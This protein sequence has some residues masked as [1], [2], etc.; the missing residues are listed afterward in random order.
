MDDRSGPRT[1]ECVEGQHHACRG[2]VWT[3]SN[4]YP[5]GCGCA[6][7]DKETP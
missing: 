4:D 5:A 7:H 3:I 1:Q 6:C 2:N